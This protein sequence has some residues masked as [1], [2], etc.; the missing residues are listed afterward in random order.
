MN[1]FKLISRWVS[2]TDED[3]NEKKKEIEKGELSYVW[4]Y[5]TFTFALDLNK[6][7]LIA[8]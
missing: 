3:I 5:V 2:Q 6:N 1:K 7:I 4:S 8:N